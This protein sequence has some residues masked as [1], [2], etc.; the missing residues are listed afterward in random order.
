MTLADVIAHH[1]AATSAQR[2]TVA[3]TPLGTAIA[4]G[5]R[6]VAAVCALDDRERAEVLS[7]VVAQL[8]A[9]EPVTA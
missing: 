3:A 8:K 5:S 6:F 1:E 4:A 9:V 2:P 7:T